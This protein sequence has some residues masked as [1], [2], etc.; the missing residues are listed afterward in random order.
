MVTIHIDGLPY[1][2][3]EGQN[4]LQA[5]LSRGLNLPYFCW[6][7]ALGSVGACRQCA[8]KRFK[9]EKDERGEIIMACMT[10]AEAGVRIS[11]DDP[12]VAAFR[13]SVIEWLMLNHPHD[14]PVC[15]EGGECHLQDMTVM[16]GHAYR[17]NRFKKRTY[18]N[19][20]LG[21]FLNHEMNR[22]IQCYRCVRY[23]HDY[24]GAGDLNVFASR[25]H[26]YFGRGRAGRLESGF[27]GN[28]VEICPTGV[29]TDKTLGRHYTRKWDLQ[30][31][32]SVCV[33]CALG[34]N[35]IPGSRYGE[36][37]RVRNRYNHEVNGY[38]LCDRGRYGYEFVNCDRRIRA[39]LVRTSR[40]VE[41]VL[42]ST[43][44]AL[45]SAAA[46]L[47]ERRKV[48]GIGSPRA[49]L[50]S[51][52]ALLRLVGP[53]N[54]HAGISDKELEVL[55][56][57]RDV[58][59]LG[60]ARTPTLSETAEAG[61]VF[62]LGEDV[63]NSAPLLALNLRQLPRRKAEIAMA[64]VKIPPWN[65]A[66]I[67]RIA[68][69]E[70]GSLY[71]AS[72]CATGL[73]EVASKSFHGD[74]S[75][76][77]RLGFAV[78]SVLDPA[79]APGVEGLTEKE[80]IR[81]GE[82]ASALGGAA[83]PL[84][85]SGAGCASL[86]L[87]EAA[88]NICTAL[89]KIGGQ[90]QIFFALPEA[91]SLG[92]ALLGAAGGLETA[93]SALRSGRADT[94]VVI[95]NDLFR[96][97]AEEKA[98]ALF[99]SAKYLVAIDHLINPTTSK[100]DLVLPA[101]AFAEASGTLVNNEGRAQRFY[102]VLVPEFEVKES[103]RWIRDIMRFLGRSEAEKWHRL[104]D[105]SVA[106]AALNPLFAG[107][108]SV[109]PDADFRL[110]GGKI[111]RQAPRYSGRTAMRAHIDVFEQPPPDDPD[112]PLTFSMEGDPRQPPPSLIPR[113][114]APGWNSVQALNKFQQEIGGPLRGKDPGVRLIEPI[115]QARTEYFRDVPASAP[116]AE[117]EMSLIPL[118][119]IFGS[120][121]L[122]A[123]SPGVAELCPQPYVALNPEDASFL[124]LFEGA[125]AKVGVEGLTCCLSVRIVPSLPRAVAGLPVGLRGAPVFELPA[126]G[127]VVR[128]AT[129]E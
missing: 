106:M 19:Q 22:C 100:A 72:P 27:S 43:E 29:F 82:I 62:V 120:E 124:G 122:S 102:R 24:A 16:T 6:H 89:G 105:L 59:C 77:A 60:A 97:C 118:H 67:Q 114:W 116:K 85:V 34:C 45:K 23:Y 108:V 81:A 35:T 56:L 20:Y 84:I 54:F 128:E 30:T 83:R 87:I 13:K 18:P 121:E 117:G 94:V 21:A 126:S 104:D 74:I 123:L 96:R 44:D 3:E 49:S 52:F 92:L 15:D 46:M 42:V 32:P 9:S 93:C 119:H 78:A 98:I 14:C 61:A 41:Q 17:E 109:A 70:K 7:P 66:P 69:F 58:L 103:W 95:E 99:D 39:P 48:I 8:V 76:L 111:P 110:A 73:D 36:L 75:E 112:T 11:I 115:P 33:H 68:E 4:L 86:A 125:L 107:L 57:I 40:G 64:K 50:E 79:N 65:D 12:E 10:P 2:V 63:S 113:Y 55:N 88:A 37:R 51:N 129:D 101:A 1:E 47:S 71:I 31:A 91:N 90:P 80:K 127:T 25:D 26:V 28:L 53:K 38:F 5:C